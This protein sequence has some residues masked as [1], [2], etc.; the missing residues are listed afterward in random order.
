[1]STSED[2]KVVI[3]ED[4]KLTRVALRYTLS[5]FPEIKITGEFSCAQDCIDFLQK[6]GE[7]DVI[8][9][10]LKLV[11]MQ[12][13]EATKIIKKKYPYIKIAIITSVLSKKDV[14][15]TINAGASA[16]I[17]KDFDFEE[18]YGIIRVIYLGAV[19]FDREASDIAYEIFKKQ[20]ANGTL[21][22]NVPKN[23]LTL[24]EK[25]VLE[26]MAQG[27]SNT[28]ISKRLY[29]SSHTAKAHVSSII[30]KLNA[31]DRVHAAVVACRSGLLD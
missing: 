15:E 25:E 5:D 13:L 20:S 30:S 26:L 21:L 18:L 7:A 31:K 2:I 12:G 10:D 22:K 29:I 1:M 3:V 6:D 19:F 16:Y 14:I 8:L 11:G 23:S 27:M 9:M 24:R 17:L 28:E 4:Y